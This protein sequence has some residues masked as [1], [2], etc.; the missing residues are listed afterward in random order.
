[1]KKVNDLLQNFLSIGILNCTLIEGAFCARKHYMLSL[2][3]Y[4][5]NKSISTSNVSCV[6]TQQ[7]L[8]TREH[9][10]MYLSFSQR[11]K[12][13]DTTEESSSLI[14][15]NILQQLCYLVYGMG[16]HPSAGVF[17]ASVFHQISLM[18][19]K[20]GKSV[21]WGISRRICQKTHFFRWNFLKVY[22]M[23]TH[24]IH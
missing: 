20:K 12:H 19:S 24:A 10:R 8:H 3:S 1:M 2:S 11:D 7:I 21:H 6:V 16:R 13:Q 14:H 15:T 22:Y 17:M 4:C 23:T 9:T 5:V 18:V